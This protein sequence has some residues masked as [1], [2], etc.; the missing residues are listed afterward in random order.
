MTVVLW[1]INVSKRL[2]SGNLSSTPEIEERM[3]S[4]DDYYE[5]ARRCISAFASGTVRSSMLKSEDAMSFVAEHLM[6]ASCR[7]EAE[8]GR[9]LHSYLNQCAIWAIR[10]WILISKNAMKHSCVSLNQDNNDE[11]NQLYNIISDGSEQ[12]V[13]ELCRKEEEAAIRSIMD[14]ELT[15]R[16]RECIELIYIQGFSGAD[17]A[18]KLGISRQAVEQCT[19]KGLTKIRT[20]LNDKIYS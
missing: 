9:T 10:R 2:E 15:D 5:V 1:G 3:L 6:Y 12:P 14:S 20:T 11:Q 4:L 16:Q 13:D 17:A 8:G 18:R 7:W 19:T